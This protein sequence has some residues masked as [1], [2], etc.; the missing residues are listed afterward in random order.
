[1]MLDLGK[2]QPIHYIGVEMAEYPLRKRFF[3]KKMEIGVSRDGVEF[4]PVD[5]D[6]TQWPEGR[7]DFQIVTVGTTV[8]GE[9]RFVRIKM[10]L[11]RSGVHLSEVI[12]N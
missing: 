1:M 4:T 9:A 10:D 7:K 5:I 6:M 3:P 8:S 2:V 12:V 11:I